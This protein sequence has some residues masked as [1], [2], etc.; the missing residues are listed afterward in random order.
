MAIY[1]AWNLHKSLLPRFRG[2]SPNFY[3]LLEGTKTVGATLHLLEEGFDTGDILMQVEIPVTEND[4][5]YSLNQKTA[6]EGGKMIAKFFGSLDLMN[7]KAFP[8]PPGEWRNY[9]YPSR[10]DIQD[11]RK[12][13]R[14]F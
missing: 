5:V 6:E 8:Q 13:K 1:G 9:S 4:G 7:I 12:K 11:F 3:A 2:M 14:R 10:K